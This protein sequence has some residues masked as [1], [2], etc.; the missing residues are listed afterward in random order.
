L[1]I[2]PFFSHYCTS[3]TT[4]AA[5]SSY[6]SGI[7]KEINMQRDFFL[8]TFKLVCLPAILDVIA[9]NLVIGSP[10]TALIPYY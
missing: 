6:S 10:L 4:T 9:I 1:L 7:S 5:S 8:E 2:P 3:T